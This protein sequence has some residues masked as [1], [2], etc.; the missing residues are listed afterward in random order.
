MGEEPPLT[1]HFGSGT[2]F[3]SHCNLRCVFCQNYDISHFGEGEIVSTERLAGLMIELQERGCH[4]INFVTPTHFAPLLVE[5]LAIGARSGLALPVVWNCGGYES[6]EVIKLLDG[7]VD[8]Y[9][10]DIKYSDEK[11]ARKYSKAPDYW[12]V[13]KEVVLE[14]HRQVGDLFVDPKGIARK[15]LLIRHLVMPNDVAGS[16]EVLKF[17]AE[18]V[19]V[20]TYVNIMAQ[21]RPCYKAVGHEKINRRPTVREFGE[22]LEMARR[23]GLTPGS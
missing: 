9:M 3:L 15:G 22:A 4:N 7:I 14:M 13:V 19:S 16:E 8:I 2:V 17:I 5:A 18:E 12:R 23:F 10:P 6:I 1:G 11:P 21:Y 20:D